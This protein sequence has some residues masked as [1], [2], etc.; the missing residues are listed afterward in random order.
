MSLQ[1]GYSPTHERL[2]FPAPPLSFE[3]CPPGPLFSLGSGIYAGK[4]MLF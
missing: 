1:Q 3:P 4:E 2:C